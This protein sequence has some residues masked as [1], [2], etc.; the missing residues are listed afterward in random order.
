[1]DHK[2]I[3]IGGIEFASTVYAAYDG[4]VIKPDTLSSLEDKYGKSGCY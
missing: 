3:D 1:M 4:V 2:G